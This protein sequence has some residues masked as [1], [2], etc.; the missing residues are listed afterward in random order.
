MV[1]RPSHCQESVGLPRRIVLCTTIRNSTT[2]IHL[3]SRFVSSLALVPSNPDADTVSFLWFLLLI[4]TGIYNITF[5]PGIFRAFDP[6]RAI[7]R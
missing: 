1:V 4:G 6:S 2:G 3:C 5:F 7:L